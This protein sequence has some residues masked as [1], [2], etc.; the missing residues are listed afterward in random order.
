MESRD[1][2]IEYNG[3]GRAFFEIK[4][5]VMQFF[6]VSN[7]SLKCGAVPRLR[8]YAVTLMRWGEDS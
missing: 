7:F 8:G 6:N 5:P 1:M 4:G 3:Y 2:Y